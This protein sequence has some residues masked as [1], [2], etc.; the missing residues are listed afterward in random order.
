[1]KIDKAI[2]DGVVVFNIL[3]FNTTQSCEGHLS[4]GYISPWI[5]FAPKSSIKYFKLVNKLTLINQQ[6]Q[7]SKLKEY[8]FQKNKKVYLEINK[9]NK[10]INNLLKTDLNKITN[11][12]N[13]FYSN[14]IAAIDQRLVI[15]DL[16]TAFQL[17]CQGSQYQNIFSEI[18]KK[19]K[20]LSYQ[21]EMQDFI[22]F[23]RKRYL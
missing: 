13:E 16:I 12:L 14:R 20:L 6:A 18:E 1:M 4:H 11:Y 9:L 5:Q 7:V 17:I 23:L 21:K 19:N 10:Q 2:L 8:N 22:E 15:I 3:G